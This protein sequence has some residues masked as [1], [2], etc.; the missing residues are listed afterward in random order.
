MTDFPGGSDGKVSACNT[1]D[2]GSIPGLGRSHGGGHGNPFQ[3]PCLENPHG[4]RSLAGY[5]PWGRK[6]SDMTEQLSTRNN[7]SLCII[8]RVTDRD[9]TSLKLP[10]GL[11]RPSH[12]A[13][14]FLFPLTQCT[15]GYSM[16]SELCIS[17]YI[18]LSFHF[19]VHLLLTCSVV[20]DSLRLHGL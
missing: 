5:S 19:W 18:V 8:L 17:W 20:S 1:G 9:V 7:G 14:L 15:M 4:Q 6:G 2:P 12:S 10:L 13:D 3:Y 16:K 11:F